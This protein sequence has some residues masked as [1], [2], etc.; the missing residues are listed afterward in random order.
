MGVLP[1]D[2]PT[3]IAAHAI[4]IM[5][6]LTLK[7]SP[8]SQN[9]D[10]N[11]E[12][13]ARWETLRKKISRKTLEALEAISQAEQFIPVQSKDNPYKHEITIVGSYLGT[14]PLKQRASQTSG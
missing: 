12:V 9:P 6:G 5:K 13:L 14:S 1:A 2:K 11:P 3:M 8:N 7:T 10:C 4:N